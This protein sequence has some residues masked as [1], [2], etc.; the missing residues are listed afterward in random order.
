M[1]SF[2]QKPGN[3]AKLKKKLP[4]EFLTLKR[5]HVWEKLDVWQPYHYNQLLRELS[6]YKH[7]SNIG[8]PK[9]V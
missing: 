8:F 5:G 2:V 6:L 9:P 7:Y 3:F 4:T 1:V